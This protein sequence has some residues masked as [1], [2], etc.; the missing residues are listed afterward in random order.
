MNFKKN[1]VSLSLP[2]AHTVRGYQIKRMPIGVFLQA[3]RGLQDFPAKALDGIFPG[4]RLEEILA[5]LKVCDTALIGQMIVRALGVVPDEAVALLANITGIPAKD[6]L[7]DENI[8]LDGL[9]EI[10]DAWIEVNGLENFM[11]A[12]RA[13]LAKVKGM[14]A[15]GTGSRN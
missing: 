6:L 1:S 7:T 9:L 10:I 4:M 3:M 14:T 2:E 11:N 5:S 8:G 13:L 15:A 12:A